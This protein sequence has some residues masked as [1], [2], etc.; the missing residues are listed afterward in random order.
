[1]TSDAIRDFYDQFP[2]PLTEARP[3]STVNGANVFRVL[4]YEL[5]SGGFAGLTF[6][7]VGCGS[8]HRILDLARTF[9]KARFVAFDISGGNI[10]V[11]RKQAELDQV[12]NIDFLQ[13]GIDEYESS[14][15]FDLI[16]ANGVLHHLPDPAGAIQKL[17]PLLKKGGLFMAWLCHPYGEHDRLLG[18]HALLT[19]LGDRQSDFE[20]GVALM[21][22]MGLSIS[23][24]RY[25]KSFGEVMTERDERSRDA[26]AFLNPLIAAFTFHQALD[27]FRNGGMAWAGIDQVNFDG[28]GAF[29]ALD[30]LE[31][32][33]PWSLDLR[34]FLKSD[35][36]F[37]YYAKLDRMD[38]LRVIES[39]V[40]PTGFTVAAGHAGDSPLRSSRMNSN[41]VVF[42]L[43]S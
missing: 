18:R 32:K 12:A 28:G 41:R 36:A 38:R 2:Y 43:E 34:P 42:D 14:E 19:L 8:G 30:D 20:A 1:M 23:P 22:E 40:K 31:R 5:R 37:E 33:S 11:A 25:G 17:R 39:L 3:N 21:H 24:S 4:D 27:L 9:P 26:D 6:L 15:T 35:G 10:D 7:D 16:I 29:L 13:C